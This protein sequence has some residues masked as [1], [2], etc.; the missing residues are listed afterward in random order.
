MRSGTPI[1]ITSLP[2]MLVS[3]SLCAE[4]LTGVVLAPKGKWEISSQKNPNKPLGKDWTEILG[5]QMLN[6]QALLCKSPP[7]QWKNTHTV[8]EEALDSCLALKAVMWANQQ[9][10]PDSTEGDRCA[11]EVTPEETE[12]IQK[13]RDVLKIQLVNSA[14]PVH[15][16][17]LIPKMLMFTLVI[18][19]LTTSNLAWFMDLI[20]KVPMQ[21]FSFTH[22]PLH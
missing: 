14:I 2:N 15:F 6:L 7:T 18:S 12:T 5:P 1:R 8:P 19:C 20:F 4:M 13:I 22:G 10:A 21:Y 16:S 11:G 17:S 3:P 9:G